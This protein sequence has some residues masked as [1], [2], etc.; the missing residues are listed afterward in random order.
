MDATMNS[1]ASK[2]RLVGDEPWATCAELARATGLSCKTL[3]RLADLCEGFPVVRIGG[4]T[5]RFVISE[6]KRFIVENPDKVAEASAR[7][8][9]KTALAGARRQKKGDA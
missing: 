7:H 5:K 3:Y 1:E 2:L 8:T 6:V 4:R 9:L